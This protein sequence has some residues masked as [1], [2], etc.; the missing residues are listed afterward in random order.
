MD[1]DPSADATS[2]PG[3]LKRVEELT[4]EAESL[5]TLAVAFERWHQDMIATMAQNQNL[6]DN[7]EDLISVA[8]QLIMVSLNAAVEAAHAGDTT[9]GFVIIA[10]EVKSLAL[11]VQELS[12]NID[13]NLHKSHLMATATFQDI[14]AGGKMMMAVISGLELMMK[15]LRLEIG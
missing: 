9:R 3:L 12:R 7:G 1:G 8:R 2:K 15:Q 4:Q 10:A 5:K 14:Q 11:R 13:K 6:N